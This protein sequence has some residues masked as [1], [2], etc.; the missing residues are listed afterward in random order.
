M[1]RRAPVPRSPIVP[2]NAADRTGTAGILRRMSAMVNARWT[3][4]AAEVLA[5]FARIPVYQLNDLRDP[6]VRYGLTPEQLAGIAEELG[7]TVQ[8]WIA[9]GRSTDYALWWE[10]FQAEAAQLGTAQSVSNLT[11]LSTVYAAARSLEQVVYSTPYVNR[12]KQAKFRSYE[13]WTGLA[14]EQR[15]KL[16]TA[17][18]QA[19]A[20]GTNPV[21]ARKAIAE[22]VGVSKTRAML[23]AQTDVTNTL[24]E[25]RWAESEAAEEELGIRTAMLWTSALIP[26]TRAWHASRN[27]KTYSTAEVKAFYAQ[28]GNRYNCRCGQ[29]ECLLDDEGK[30]ILT[31]KLQS[32]MANEK[33]AWQSRYVK[34]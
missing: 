26:S 2:G 6:A 23:Y 1:A 18:G 20:D 28:G 24:R 15:T 31:K 25:A 5:I 27:G 8:R 32:S 7:E 3:M 12:I 11:R 9:G 19:V 29:T 21:A 33:K 10:P 13:H 17:I 30:P 16:A 22:A 34:G 4:M 14:A